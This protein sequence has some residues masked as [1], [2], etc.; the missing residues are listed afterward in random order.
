[1]CYFHTDDWASLETEAGG[2]Y[3]EIWKVNKGFLDRQISA[4]KD[5]YLVDDPNLSYYLDNGDPRLFQREIDYLV[6]REYSFEKVGDG[7]WRAICGG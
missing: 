3:D 4:G 6:S 7:L 5:I 2:N 1:M